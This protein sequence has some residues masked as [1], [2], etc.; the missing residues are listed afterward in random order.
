MFP[1][2]C[3]RIDEHLSLFFPPLNKMSL[4][5][6]KCS[7]NGQKPPPLRSFE[8]IAGRWFFRFGLLQSFIRPPLISNQIFLRFFFIIDFPLLCRKAAAWSPPQPSPLYKVGKAATFPIVLPPPPLLCQNIVSM[9]CRH[10]RV[11]LP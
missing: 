11:L 4:L 9:L 10:R 3:I 5:F 7:P 2:C 1:S 8:F 6:P